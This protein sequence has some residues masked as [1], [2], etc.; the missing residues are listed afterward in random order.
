[1]SAA[2]YQH[3][4]NPLGGGSQGFPGKG[5]GYTAQTGAAKRIAAREDCLK[6]AYSPLL[7]YVE[8]SLVL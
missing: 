2:I 4:C 7:S 5:G 6:R 1:M 3:F 8:S